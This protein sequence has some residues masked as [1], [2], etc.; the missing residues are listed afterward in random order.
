MT[1]NNVS[2]PQ[3]SPAEARTV[4]AMV[5]GSPMVSGLSAAALAVP[6][7]LLAALPGLV[8][9]AGFDHLAYGIGLLAGVV[10]AG[11]WIAPKLTMIGAASV[12]DALAMKFGT[13]VARL[14]A[15]I[16]I[17]VVIPLLMAEFALVAAVAQGTAFPTFSIIAATL[18]LAAIGALLLDDRPFRAVT[19]VAFALFAASL[20]VPLVLLALKVDGGGVPLIGYGRT[21]P[22]IGALEEKLLGAGLVDFDTFSSHVAAFLKMT[23]LDL[24][25]LVVT[26]ALG[27]AVFPPL[28]GSVASARGPAAARLVGAWTALLVM[29]L[30]AATPAL[31]AYAKLQIYGAMTSATPLSKLPQ[32][33]EAPSRAGLAHI[34]GTSAGQLE[35][36]AVAVRAGAE[37]TASVAEELE[38]KDAAAK[39][40]A[41]LDPETQEAILASARTLVMEPGTSAWD[42]Y[43]TTVAPS[44]AKAQGNVDMTLSQAALVIEPAGL[45]LA[46]PEMTGA[47]R[48]ILP[49]G[50]GAAALAMVM[51]L[52]RTLLSLRAT[53]PLRP[54]GPGWRR[55]ALVATAAAVAAGGAVLIDT[56]DL[57][58]I[59]VGSLSLAAAGLFPA[60][61]IGLS[62]RRATA[63]GA[64]AAIIAG[65]GLSLYYEAGTQAYPAA[66]YETWPSLSNAGEPAIEEFNTLSE[67][68]RDAKEGEAK[69]AAATALDDW[70]RGTATRPGLANWR[71]ISGATSAIFAVPFG[72]LMLI[73]VSLV[74]RPRRTASPLGQPPQP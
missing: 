17:L 28:L 66:F 3:T 18:V 57:V 19:A 26:L 53:V 58:T 74:T 52:M 30:L 56:A 33:L 12:T 51:A 47:P 62:W 13:T 67:A 68:W 25:A 31:A 69:A 35:T 45:L 20:I 1:S 48:W 64:A 21:I 24:V 37:T 11:V 22:E 7:A 70:A 42:L 36:V 32:W 23:P 59:V 8:Y 55:I 73:L 14:A 27:T 2:A 46:L 54:G 16:V 39:Q 50:I 5:S 10:L 60:V 34:H 63:I 6:V 72:L 38:L 15:V 65:A 40:W 43:Q 29:V 4:S 9:A 49:L 44:A 71:G 41:A 61:A